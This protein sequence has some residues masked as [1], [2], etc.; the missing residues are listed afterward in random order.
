[1]A[2]KDISDIRKK[3]IIFLVALGSIGRSLPTAIINIMS[4]Y[5]ILVMNYEASFYNHLIERYASCING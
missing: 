5:N 2:D 4:S 1:M 3:P